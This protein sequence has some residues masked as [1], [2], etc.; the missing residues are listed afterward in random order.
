MTRIG[1]DTNVLA[2][3]AGVDRHDDDAAKIDMSQ[4]LF[5]RLHSRAQIV[6]PVQVLGELFVV[7]TRSGE[8]RDAAREAVLR[9]A[10]TFAIVDS[11]RSGFLAALDLATTHKMQLWDSLILN[12]AAEAGCAFLLSE[13]MGDGFAWRGTVV[14]NPLVDPPDDRLMDLL[15]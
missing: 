10:D 3:Y 6:L 9:L 13:D 1:V 2:Y 4:D 7:L 12:A 5:A 14:I 8:P 11:T 15:T